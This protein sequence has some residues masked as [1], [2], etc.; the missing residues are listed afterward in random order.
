MPE[1]GSRIIVDENGAFIP[2]R[3]FGQHD[4]ILAEL[5]EA[6]VLTPKPQVK[7]VPISD[8]AREMRWLKEHRQQY[9]GQ[10][11]ALDGDKLVSHGVDARA[12]YEAARQAG[13]AVSFVA[14]VDPAE[15][16]PFG[17]W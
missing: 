9:V 8:R 3:M 7:Y 10:W 15:P 11:G 2:K 5:K 4:R 12:V 14:H 17:G 6:G 1:E 13:V 16:Y